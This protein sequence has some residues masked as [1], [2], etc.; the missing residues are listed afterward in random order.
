[1]HGLTSVDDIQETAEGVLAIY[2]SI[3]REDITLLYDIAEEMVK[4]TNEKRK[5]KEVVA[6]C[7]VG[8]KIEGG[9][10]MMAVVKKEV[11]NIPVVRVR[12][13]YRD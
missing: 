8:I 7:K 10:D 5:G 2:T 13:S 11:D 1:M 3:S 4:N 9:D 6:E 12:I